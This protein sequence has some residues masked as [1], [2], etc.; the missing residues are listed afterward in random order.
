MFGRMKRFTLLLAC[1]VLCAGSMRLPANASGYATLYLNPTSRSVA[2]QQSFPVAVRVS[3]SGTAYDF[4]NAVLHFPADKLAVESVANG[5]FDLQYE[6]TA[7]NPGGRLTLRR[8]ASNDLSG[9]RLI[10]TVNFKALAGGSAAVNYD[11]TS[12]VILNE[13]Y[14]TTLAYGGNYTITAPTPPPAQPPAAPAPPAAAPRPRRQIASPATPPASTPPAEVPAQ[15]ET[16]AVETEEQPQQP[17]STFPVKLRILSSDDQPLAGAEI[18]INDSK[19][20]SND[21]G[22]VQLRL[23]AGEPTAQVSAKG[24]QTMTHRFTVEQIETGSMLSNFGQQ[25]FIVVLERSR[26]LGAVLIIGGIIAAAGLVLL[27]VRLLRRRSPAP[28]YPAV[29]SAYNDPDLHLPATENEVAPPVEPPPIAPA[30]V[31]TDP[32]PMPAFESPGAP[33]P[34]WQLEVE[35]NLAAMRSEQQIP[36]PIGPEP[37]DMFETIDNA[38]PDKAPADTMPK[39]A[40]PSS[41]TD[42]PLPNPFYGSQDYSS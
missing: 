2:A 30:A 17:A 36:D 35:R 38:P 9:D 34:E 13:Q 3:G 42:L 15:P 16:P 39:T 40:Q 10:A 21:A 23:P 18:T 27:M 7:N 37:H 25:E 29:A 1:A 26:S 19:E 28:V 4:V 33:T 20:I 32:P 41:S 6:T 31:P 5:D 8:G 11:G 24:Y 22:E 12:A 14:V